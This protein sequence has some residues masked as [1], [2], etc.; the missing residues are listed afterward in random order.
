MRLIGVGLYMEMKKCVLCARPR[1]KNE[2]RMCDVCQQRIVNEFV[3]AYWK[4]IE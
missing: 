3:D 2:I 1:T 4:A